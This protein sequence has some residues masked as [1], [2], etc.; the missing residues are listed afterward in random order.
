MMGWFLRIVWTSIGKKMVMALT[1]LIFISF[2]CVHLLGNLTIYGGKDSLLNYSSR[3]HSL[4]III[5]L[6]EIVLLLC[7]ILHISFG[8]IL[9]L[10]NIRARPVSYSMKRYEGG[11]TLSSA[12]MPYS[13]AF[14]LIFVIFHLF[15]FHFGVVRSELYDVVK[16]WFSSFPYVIFYILGMIAV[17]LHVRHGFWSAFQSLG[18]NHPKYMGAIWVLS[19]ILS[20]LFL[21]GFGSIPLYMFF[22]R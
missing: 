1:G 12:L 21:I 5:N 19:Y 11:R 15:T 16:R 8:L 2:L 10:E 7:A 9:F 17:A 13:G 20:I 6:I 3:L 4:G 18:L 22:I 14:L